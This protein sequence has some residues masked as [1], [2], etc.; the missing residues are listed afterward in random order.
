MAAGT[1]GPTL[2]SNPG[3]LG[4]SLFG[5]TGR[6]ISAVE[7]GNISVY[8]VSTSAVFTLLGSTSF[9]GGANI[10]CAAYDVDRDIVYFGSASSPYLAAYQIG[11]SG[12]ITPITVPTPS[13]PVN[14]IAILYN[15]DWKQFNV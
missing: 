14:R 15:G 4:Y 13:G 12:G 2:I 8:D 6:F 3:G 11:S 7:G 1:I 10:K 9:S 5:P